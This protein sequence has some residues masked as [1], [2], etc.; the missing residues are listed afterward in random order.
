MTL[1]CA[2][3]VVEKDRDEDEVVALQNCFAHVTVEDEHGIK[4]GIS[5]ALIAMNVTQ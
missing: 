2:R 5:N 1:C 3:G 4:G